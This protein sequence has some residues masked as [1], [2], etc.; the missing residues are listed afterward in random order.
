MTEQDRII[1]KIKAVAYD[2]VNKKLEEERRK[3]EDKINNEL[4]DVEKCLAYIKNKLVYKIIKDGRNTVGY[5]LADEDMF[6]TDYTNEPKN[7]YSHLGIQ[8]FD[9]C[10]RYR[11]PLFK[12]N[13]EEYYDIRKIINRYEEDFNDYA[14]RLRRLSADFNE[15]S[16]R[17]N[18]LKKQEPHIKKLIEAY[19]QV[20]INETIVIND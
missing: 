15:I 17:A 12:V 7:T 10:D 11:H 9:T 18:E 19:K 14:E 2:N 13:G 6:F 5:E 20:E 3:N 1:S 16:K 8:F 4:N